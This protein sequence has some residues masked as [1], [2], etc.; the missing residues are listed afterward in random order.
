MVNGWKEW[1]EKSLLKS[2]SS[3]F[4]EESIKNQPL[5][6]ITIRGV[7]IDLVSFFAGRNI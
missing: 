4:N 7:H 3:L 5:T 2:E 1:I 6:M